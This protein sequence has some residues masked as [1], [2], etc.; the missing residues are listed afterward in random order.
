MTYAV[1][2]WG[3]AHDEPTTADL[4]QLAP[5][6]AETTGIPVQEPFVPRPLHDLP[7]AR[8]D[9]PSALAG[10]AS[11]DGTDRARH[12]I[13]RSYRDLIRAVRGELTDVVRLAARDAHGNRTVRRLK[14]VLL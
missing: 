10:L 1:W 8:T 12:G 5:F 6:V 4:A 14:R 11:S 9:V 2:G 7:A 13:G 3:E